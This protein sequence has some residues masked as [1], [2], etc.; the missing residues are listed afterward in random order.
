[1]QIPHVLILALLLASL[2]ALAAAGAPE[3]PREGQ[4]FRIGAA[5]RGL[6]AVTPVDPD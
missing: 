1:M 4:P 3:P 6:V 5:L 2:P